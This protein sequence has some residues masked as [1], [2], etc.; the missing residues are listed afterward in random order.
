MIKGVFSLITLYSG[1]PGSGKSYHAAQNI[2]YLLRGRKNVICNIP[3]NEKACKQNFFHYWLSK[4]LRKE[5]VGSR[6]TGCFVYKDN[7]AL[8]PAFLIDYAKKNHNRKK[9]G[10]TTVVIDECGIMFNPRTFSQSDRLEWIQFFSLHRHYGYDFIL[11]SQ[12]DR[13]LDRQ[14]R[15]FI[16]YEHRH[17][18]ATNFGFGGMLL[19]FLTMST[20]FVD[21]KLWYGLREKVGADWIRYSGRIAS[22]YDTMYLEDLP[23]DDADSPDGQE[24]D[25]P[26]EMGDEERGGP[27]PDGALLSPSPDLAVRIYDRE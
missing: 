11:I 10:Q 21:V 24:E 13:M 8:T 19:H 1:T 12:S 9:E 17:R 7:M 14:I 6:E 26:A 15:S 5:I 4:I 3:I 27:I 22:V 18:K 25:A 20:F 16:E 2:F 23:D